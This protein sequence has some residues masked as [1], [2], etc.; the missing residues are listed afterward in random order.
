VLEAE[1]ARR[2]KCS[3]GIMI[4]QKQANNS[5][6]RVFGGRLGRGLQRHLSRYVEQAL[7]DKLTVIFSQCNSRPPHLMIRATLVNECELLIEVTGNGLI[8]SSTSDLAICINLDS[9]PF[10]PSFLIFGPGVFQIEP[11]HQ[12]ATEPGW[13]GR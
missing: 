4:H 2:M 3:S 5:L 12:E 13:F 11:P 9:C 7:D 1:T 8:G 6:G 10:H